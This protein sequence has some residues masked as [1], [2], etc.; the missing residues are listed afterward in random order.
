LKKYTAEKLRNVALIGHGGCGKTSLVEAALFFTKSVDRLGRVDDGSSVMD[1]DPEET[2]RKIS[3]STALAPLEYK[4]HKINLL[5][6]PGFF[7]F[8]GEVKSALR[9]ADA[10][11]IVVCAVSGAEVGVDKSWDYTEAQ[12]IPKAFFINKMDRENADFDKVY[13]AL[14]ERF[15]SRVVPVQVPIGSADK[16]NGIVDVIRNKAYTGAGGKETAGP[17]PADLADAAEE[18]RAMLIEAAAESDDDLTAKYLEGESLTDA[19]I[20]RGLHQATLTGKLVPVFC[21]SAAK[22]GGM[23]ALLTGLVDCFPSPV[24]RGDVVGTLPS[25]DETNR[26]PTEGEPAAALVWK[27]TADPFVGKLTVFRVYSGSLKS[28]GT[29]WNASKGKAERLGQLFLVKGKSQEP[30]PEIS[31]GDFGAVAKLADTSTG[32]TLCDKDKPIILPGIDF[33]KPSLTMAVEPKA[34]SDEDK[35]S[36]GLTRL[37]EEDPTFVTS[38]DAATKEIL[39]SGTGDLH[40]EVISS[41][42]HKKFG[43][44]VNLKSPKVPYKETIRGSAK[45]EG[46]HKKQSGGRGQFGHIWLAL[47]ALPGVEFEFVDKIFGGSVPRQYIPAVEKGLHESMEEGPIAGYPVTNI[48]AILYDG[49]YHS[50]DSSEM[51][52]KIAA[53][54][55]FKKAFMDA[56]PVLLE[57][58]MNMEITVPDHYMGDI[59]G[60]ITKKRG[61]VFGMEPIGKGMQVIKA[62][63]PLAEVFKYAIDL[64]SMTQGRGSFTMAFDRYEEVPSNLAEAV[65]AEHKKN[66]S[67][68]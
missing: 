1:Y 36:G 30:V 46:K 57:P 38:R 56:K 14:R 18:Y 45:A 4:D 29:I 54:L 47:E 24:E 44:E 22:M 41:K 58:V 62:Q 59:I 61:R 53:H 32:D 40:L 33:P 67:E 63:A 49:S 27:T 7:D 15:G 42:L 8:V 19:E 20:M 2:K 21:G 68:E 34:K 13:T 60:D 52:F 6:T 55:G 35:I 66:V 51:A 17:V 25:G 23:E 48:R 31:A 26:K 10:G 37:M 64:R 39:V 65:I 3:V 16:F 11:L 12:G 9:V 28:D 5:D 50:V 43:V